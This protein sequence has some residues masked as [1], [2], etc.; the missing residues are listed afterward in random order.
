MVRRGLILELQLLAGSEL[1]FP[2]FDDVVGL[3]RPGLV[4]PGRGFG[5]HVVGAAS[6][7]HGA[8]VPRCMPTSTRISQRGKFCGS[9]KVGSDQAFEFFNST[10][11]RLSA[12]GPLG[13]GPR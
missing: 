7:G 3:R 4:G 12:R 11:A 13:C 9:S 5:S 10:S 6:D 1:F 2:P 8:I